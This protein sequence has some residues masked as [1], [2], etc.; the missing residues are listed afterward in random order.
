MLLTHPQ[1]IK[2][3]TKDGQFANQLTIKNGMVSDDE[4]IPVPEVMIQGWNYDF[5]YFA[6]DV[7]I[8]TYRTNHGG[9]VV[10]ESELIFLQHAVEAIVDKNTVSI[11]LIGNAFG[12]IE[13]I[14]VPIVVNDNLTLS[15]H[16]DVQ[17]NILNWMTNLGHQPA[18]QEYGKL[19]NFRLTSSH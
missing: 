9:N 4:L 3:V 16:N 18:K 8:H 17:L 1:I 15:F 11:D 7:V 14:T 2:F 13:R 5:K 19:I 12:N 10:E 6:G